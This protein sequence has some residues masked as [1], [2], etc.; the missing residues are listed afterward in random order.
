MREPTNG[1]DPNAIAVYGHW[2]SERPR[3]FRSPAID[4]HAEQIGYLPAEEAELL[5]TVDREMPIAA[6]LYG[7]DLA[8]PADDSGML[9]VIIK[10]LVLVP[11]ATDPHWGRVAKAL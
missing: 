9:G 4:H 1:Y 2:T 6:E 10:I 11:S 8:P 7:I 3:W 5:G